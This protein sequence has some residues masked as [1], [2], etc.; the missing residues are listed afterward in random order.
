MAGILAER[1]TINARLATGV[2]DTADIAVAMSQMT[3]SPE[4][5][6]LQVR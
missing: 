2:H 6:V 1:K 3:V 4:C 5:E